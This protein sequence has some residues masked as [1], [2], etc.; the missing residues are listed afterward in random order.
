MIT[1]KEQ[2]KEYLKI[3]NDLYVPSKSSIRNY[4]LGGPDI[5]RWKYIKAYR[6]LEYYYNNRNKNVV[7]AILNLHYARKFNRI[8]FKLG[9]ELNRNVFEEGLM[10]YHTSGIVVNGDARIGKNCKLH[11]GNVIGN[12]GNDL[13]APIIGNNVRLGTGAKIL[14]DVYIADDVQIGAGAIVLNSCY[15]KGALLIGIPAKVHSSSKK[16]KEVRG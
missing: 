11:G 1:T 15:E 3:E 8:G 16:T 14:G 10:I 5:Y 12:K 7:Y 6:K 9:I 2:L 13:K 4:I